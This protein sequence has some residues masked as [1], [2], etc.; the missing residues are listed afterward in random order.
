MK[1][2][3][4]LAAVLF[5]IFISVSAF[6]ADNDPQFKGPGQNFEK[7]KADII[8]RIDARIAR[9]QEEKSCVQAAQKPADVK[10]CQEKFKADNRDGREQ[11]KK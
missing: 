1:H 8:S 7:R 6:A 3:Q 4:A 11:M 5:L 10:A 2:I 9:N